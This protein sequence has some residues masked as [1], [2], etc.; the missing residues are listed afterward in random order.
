MHHG[1]EGAAVS[2]ASHGREDCITTISITPQLREKVART[3]T[4]EPEV[5][6]MS[7]VSPHRLPLSPLESLLLKDSSNSRSN[8][9]ENDSQKKRPRLTWGQGLAKYE[10]EKIE[11]DPSV[12]RKQ[13]EGIQQEHH[14][15]AAVDAMSDHVPNN[16]GLTCEGNWQ[17][18]TK[19]MDR[20]Y[21]SVQEEQCNAG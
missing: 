20:N 10:K 6:S 16:I 17:Q 3:S 18:M 5:V 4:S 2:L 7:I 15:N 13:Q 19:N 1:D 12:S 8:N 14:D 21:Q 11:E 9:G